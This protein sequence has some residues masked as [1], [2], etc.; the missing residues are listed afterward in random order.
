MAQAQVSFFQ[1]GV[2]RVRETVDSIEH[3]FARVQKDL[4]KDLRS[5]RRR[6]E[7]QLNASRRDF[8]KRRK[9]IR[10]DLQKN[11]TLKQVEDLRKRAT[12]QIEQGVDGVLALFQ[13]ASKS[14]VERIDRKLTQLNRRLRE[15]D[16][17][18]HQAP[19]RA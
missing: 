8:E 5:R 16:S 9:R 2:D 15:L 10:R 11:P 6:L 1:D 19:R 12:D 17:K 4:Q 3:E 7:K 13:I 14:D 18:K